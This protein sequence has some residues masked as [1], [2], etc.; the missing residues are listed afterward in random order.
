MIDVVI[1]PVTTQ[2]QAEE[3][4]RILW[5]GLW[6][7]IGLPRDIRES[8]KLE[9]ACIELVAT[10]GPEVL[11]GLV[12]AVWLCADTLELRHIAL[13]PEFQRMS[14]GT[15]LVRE[16]VAV[17]EAGRCLVIET[18]ARNTSVGFFA[19]LGFVTLPREPLKHPDFSKHGISFRRMEYSL[20]ALSLS[21]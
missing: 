5:Q 19:S 12:A 11:G 1:E 8:F 10:R 17:A 4:D 6:Q 14:I 18:Y 13:R 2:A 20:S 7:P 9:G 15:K 3:L 21:E 16:L